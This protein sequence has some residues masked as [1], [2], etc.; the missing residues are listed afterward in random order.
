MERLQKIGHL[1]AASAQE[2]GWS[3]LGVGFEK[4]DRKAFDPENAYQLVGDLGVHYVR[5]QSGWQR[6]ER[7]K[8]VYDFAWLDAIVDRFLAQGQ[9]PWID[10]CYGNDLYTESAKTYYGAVG[11][12]PIGSDEEKAA[13]ARYVE[14]LAAHLPGVSHGMRS[15]M[16]QT[17]SG[18]GSMGPMRLSSAILPWRQP[19]QYA[20]R[21]RKPGSLA[22]S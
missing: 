2:I 8:G 11:C 1:K 7:E 21:I 9:E 16:R 5:L 12:P 10:L 13:W 4:L 22:V 15:G 6:T 18:A 17:G 3:R 19:G 20:E 14:T